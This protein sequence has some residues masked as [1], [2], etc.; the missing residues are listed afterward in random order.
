MTAPLRLIQRVI[1]VWTNNGIPPADDGEIC[2]ELRHVR[3]PENA[4]PNLL[5]WRLASPDALLSG[6]S[7][8]HSLLHLRHQT[9]GLHR[10]YH[11]NAPCCMH[12]HGR[13][14]VSPQASAIAASQLQA[15][16]YELK[17]LLPLSTYSMSGA[18]SCRCDT[19]CCVI[20][21]RGYYV[22]A[23]CTSCVFWLHFGIAVRVASSVSS[24][25]FLQC[26]QGSREHLKVMAS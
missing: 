21:S 2:S 25:L 17:A 18:Q 4:E 22:T 5:P 12:V 6:Y 8:L 11:S 16:F 7:N 9:R 13:W 23:Q 26:L 20:V 19:F 24:A 1:R 10:P 3:V 15:D 14:P